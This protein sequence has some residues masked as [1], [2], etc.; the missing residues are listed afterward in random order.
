MMWLVCL[1][2]VT[3]LVETAI[4]GCYRWVQ[5]NMPEQSIWVVLGAKVVKILVAIAAILAVYT[6]ADGVKI[7]HFGIAVV[8]VYLL[9]LVLE[10]VFFLKK[11]K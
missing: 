7:E 6:F 2:V 3:R 5:A 1:V 9:S 10:T 8:T 11:K 4:I